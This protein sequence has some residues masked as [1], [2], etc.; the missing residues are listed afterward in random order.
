MRL[1][2]PAARKPG[3]SQTR[4]HGLLCQDAGLVGE[5]GCGADLPTPDLDPGLSKRLVHPSGEAQF[6]DLPVPGGHA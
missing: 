3:R 5:R 1:V 4:W 2:V 6:S